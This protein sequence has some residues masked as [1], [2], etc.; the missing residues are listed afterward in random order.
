MA[1]LKEKVQATSHAS[2]KPAGR[3]TAKVRSTARRA[4]AAD[5]ASPAAASS[6]QDAKGLRVRMFRVGFG[7][8]FLLTVPT[9]NG[10][11]HILIDCGV[12][13]RD[14]NTIR[15]AVAQMAEDCGSRLAL[16]I[17]THRHADHISGFATCS[18]IFSQITVDRVWMPWFEDPS[19]KA[20]KAFQTSLTALAGRLLFQL[21]ARSGDSELARMAENITGAI[22]AATGAPP[23]KRRSMCSTTDSRTIRSTTITGPATCRRFPRI[24]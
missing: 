18:D 23:T 14:L 10:A 11:R 19:N 22:N 6:S 17:M 15:D 2:T 3:K 7:D 4:P 8:F 12:H 21:A 5:A 24:W 20:A 1:T 16:V 9:P 13:A